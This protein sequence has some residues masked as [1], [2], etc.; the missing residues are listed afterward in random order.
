MMKVVLSLLFGMTLCVAQLHAQ[1]LPGNAKNVLFLGDSITYA[2]QYTADVE[3]F[4]ILRHQAADTRFINAGLPSETVSGLSPVGHAGGKFPMPVLHD[5]LGRLLAHVRPD[6]VFVCYGMNDGIMQPFDD[7]RFQAF[8]NGMTATHEQIAKTGAKII[9][10]TPP[11]FDGVKGHNDFYNG[12][13]DHYTQWLLGQ[14][15]SA[16]WTVIDLHGPMTAYLDGQRKTNPGFFFANDGVHPD[17][18]GHWVMAQQILLGLGATEVAAMKDDAALAAMHPHG[19]AILKLVREREEMLRSTTL[20]LT[21]HKR[22]GLTPGIPRADADRQSAVIEQ[23]I[24][25]LLK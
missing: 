8:K 24:N 7:E 14:R 20:T 4:F 17:D 13:L 5:R 1:S 22:P 15:Q 9:H 19:Q 18:L 25:Q 11:V 10:L 12:V 2:G 3:T 16:G 23:K 21:G 6:L